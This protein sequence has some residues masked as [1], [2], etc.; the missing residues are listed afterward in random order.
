MDIKKQSQHLNP[1]QQYH[2]L[3]MQI[4]VIE[5]ADSTTDE[6]VEPYPANGK[7][8]HK[9][10][11][12]ALVIT[13]VLAVLTVSLSILA[14]Q[15]LSAADRAIRVGHYNNQ[16][17]IMEAVRQTREIAARGIPSYVQRNQTVNLAAPVLQNCTQ[18]TFEQGALITFD[19][20]LLPSKDPLDMLTSLDKGMS[21]A[22]YQRID[23]REAETCRHIV[24][25]GPK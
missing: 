14:Y 2:V 4:P 5:F 12:R 17:A 9:T 11:K 20:T 21:T 16:K 23:Q 8:W 22:G 6:L 3:R 19:Y 1:A 25:Y 24:T 18:W 7:K 10:S 13:G 15:M